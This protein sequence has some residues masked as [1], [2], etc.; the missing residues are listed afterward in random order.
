MHIR[1]SELG[2]PTQS[3]KNHGL[4]IMPG[5]DAGTQIF[6]LMGPGL[7]EHTDITRGMD[8]LVNKDILTGLSNSTLVNNKV[9]RKLR[10][11]NI[12]KWA[13]TNFSNPVHI[14]PN[15]KVL[16]PINNRTVSKRSNKVLIKL[17]SLQVIRAHKQICT[18]VKLQL[19]TKVHKHSRH[20]PL[21]PNNTL[22]AFKAINQ[23]PKIFKPRQHVPLHAAKNVQQLVP[24][25]V[26]PNISK[27]LLK[28]KQAQPRLVVTVRSNVK[29]NVASIAHKNAVV[30]TCVPSFVES[31]VCPAVQRNAV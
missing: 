14:Q 17:S 26:A 10:P 9:W 3:K 23:P 16:I 31:R 13:V 18:K 1:G 22:Q 21:L 4:L 30:L 24:K 28:R 19:I 27:K 11:H 29:P 7:Q 25:N 15:H 12:L 6:N 2:I 20:K 5:K 8:A